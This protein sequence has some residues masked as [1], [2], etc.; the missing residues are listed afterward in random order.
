MFMRKEKGNTLVELMLAGGILGIITLWQVKASTQARLDIDAKNYA[1]Q[2]QSLYGA[3]AQYA[4]ANRTGIV[5]ATGGVTPELYCKVNVATDGSGGTT[6]NNTTKG[7]CAVDV[8]WLV[9]KGVLPGSFPHAAP[10]GSRWVVIYRKVNT[11]DLEALVVAASTVGADTVEVTPLFTKGDTLE[12][13]AALMGANAGVVPSGTNHPCPWH[14]SDNSQRFI[15]GTGG[16]WRAQVG[17]F[18]N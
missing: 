10:D 6:A 8:S 14:A 11:S 15:C 3:G 5:D 12:K 9:Y 13:A 16:A 2:M 18:V 1:E 7:T 17:N 4:M